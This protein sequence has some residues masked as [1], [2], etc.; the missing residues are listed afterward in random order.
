MVL[1]TVTIITIENRWSKRLEYEEYREFV[2][3]HKQNY[4]W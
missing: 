2:K 1:L 4:T 3:V